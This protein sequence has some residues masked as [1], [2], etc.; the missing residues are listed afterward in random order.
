[1][2]NDINKEIKEALK[3]D[4]VPATP[5]AEVDAKGMPVITPHITGMV[6]SEPGT[7]R[8]VLNTSSFQ[9]MECMSPHKKT[10]VCIVEKGEYPK[11]GNQYVNSEGFLTHIVTQNVFKLVFNALTS[12]S[13]QIKEHKMEASLYKEKAELYKMT[14]D[15]FKKSGLIE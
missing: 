15:A 6:A 5:I 10:R 8:V 9:L 13:A 2:F 3:E 14:I 11:Y 4:K 12:A 7:E 1:M